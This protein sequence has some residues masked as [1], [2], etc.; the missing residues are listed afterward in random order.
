MKNIKEIADEL[1]SAT[2]AE[3]AELNGFLTA[4]NFKV[5]PLTEIKQIFEYLLSLNEAD[6]AFVLTRMVAD[7]NG[8][9][10][11]ADEG[12]C[13][14]PCGGPGNTPNGYWSCINKK[15]VWI[16]SLG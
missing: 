8:E 1:I 7:L 10:R 5:V 13:N 9:P 11:P 14:P 6:R 2:E 4:S 15:C 16:P 3:L 12:T